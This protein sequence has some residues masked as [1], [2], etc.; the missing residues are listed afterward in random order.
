M[1]SRLDLPW[2]CQPPLDFRQ[3]LKNLVN[4][5]EVPLASLINLAAYALNLDQL[6][7][8]YQIIRTREELFTPLSK[9]RLGVISN[10]TTKLLAPC[11]SATGLRYSFY[12]NVIEGQTIQDAFD[13]HSDIQTQQLDVILIALDHRGIPGLCEAFVT[14]EQAAVAESM[15]FIELIREGLIRKPVRLIF[16]TVP[17]PPEVFFGNTD[18]R[19]PGSRS[20]RI[21]LFNQR[22]TD[23]TIAWGDLLLDVKH[24]ADSVGL[25]QWFDESQWHMSKLSVAPNMIPLYSDYCLR[26]MAL[27]FGKN[28]RKCLVLDLDNTIWGGEIGDDGL[29][30]ITLGEGSAAGEAYLAVQK[31]ALAL[32]E[33]GILLA[34]CSKNDEQ[35]ARLPF[36][37]HP[38]MLLRE[39]HIAVFLANWRDK[40]TNLSAIAAALNI[41]L[42]ALVFLDDNPAERQQVRD[43][44]PM[45][46]VPELPEDPAY[47]PRILLAGG[48]FDTLFFSQEDALRAEH[49]QANA[50]RALE[51][52]KH[53][54]LDDYLQSLAMMI[55][56]SPFDAVG[57]TRIT[58]LI[59]KSNQF[60][61]TTHRYSETDIA[62]LE[63][64]S[65]VYTLQIRLTD[66]FGDNGMI[67]VII[68]RIQ[69]TVWEIDTWLMSCRVINR[70]VEEAV[71]DHI[72]ENMQRHG[73]AKLIG[74]YIP[75]ER[76]HL[77]KD[78][79]QK[80]GFT[81]LQSIDGKEHWELSLDD[82]QWKHPPMT[83]NHHSIFSAVSV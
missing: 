56:F 1:M 62:A 31:M 50:E 30:G 25:D 45:V 82:Y 19:I 49:Y 29:S 24:L 78:H 36:Q 21:N 35:I 22:L 2:L 12:V 11:L 75:T 40:A 28:I 81:F 7:L 16:Q 83:I 69:K 55:T 67:G 26:L 59:A 48:Y 15:K 70:R 18:T 66:K 80:M 9:L 64:N 8:F 53:R 17:S 61:L 51:I 4:Q 20:R 23:A 72:V 76:N 5:N 33:R 6:H 77:V 3:R 65:A 32:R 13:M 52:S 57:R 38:E 46:A 14:D 63:K 54:N 73:A 60:N 43:A 37:K 71:L 44:L 58:Q 10:G 68:C 47:F 79:Y 34:V 39:E 42:D 41:G 27:L 74:I